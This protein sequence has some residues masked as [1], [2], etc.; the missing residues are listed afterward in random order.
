MFFS[1]Q[2]GSVYNDTKNAKLGDMSSLVES[3][4]LLLHVVRRIR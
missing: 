2:D 1:T 4:M 3:N